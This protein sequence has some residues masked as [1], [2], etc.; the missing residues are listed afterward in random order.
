MEWVEFEKCVCNG[1]TQNGAWIRFPGKN[2]DIFIP[3]SHMHDDCEVYLNGR[4][5]TAIISEWIAKQTGLM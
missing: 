4:K 5:G 1:K 3:Y 2:K